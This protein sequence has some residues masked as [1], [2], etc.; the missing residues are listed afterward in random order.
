MFSLNGHS[1]P[2]PSNASIAIYFEK[3]G[4]SSNSSI[5]QGFECSEEAESWRSTEVKS[6]LAKKAE[7]A[8]PSFLPP[9]IM[10][11]SDQQDTSTSSL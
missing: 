6:W 5:W 8:D 9:A 3:V 7:Q 4:S 10:S 2:S 11:H 1:N